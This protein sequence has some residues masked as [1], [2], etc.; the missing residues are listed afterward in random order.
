MLKIKQTPTAT[1]RTSCGSSERKNFDYMLYLHQTI[2]ESLASTSSPYSV[3]YA[4][5]SENNC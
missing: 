3:Y 5:N 4:L 1:N 2:Q